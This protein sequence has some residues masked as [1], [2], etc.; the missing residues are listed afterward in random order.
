M[1][2]APEPLLPSPA[3]SKRVLSTAERVRQDQNRADFMEYLFLMDG[4]DNP[5]HPYA[6]TYTGLFSSYAVALGTAALQDIQEEW[7]TF[8][9]CESGDKGNESTVA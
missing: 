9:F 3:E 1:N 4:R 5:D 6:F 7:H 2:E 8:E